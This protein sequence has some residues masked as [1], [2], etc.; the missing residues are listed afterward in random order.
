MERTVGSLPQLFL[1]AARPLSFW[2]KRDRQRCSSAELGLWPSPGPVI[3]YGLELD[4]VKDG[5]IGGALC[6]QYVCIGKQ[7]NA[8]DD[9]LSPH[10]FAA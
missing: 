1:R 2:R 8:A 3:R 7:C 9:H 10:R 5:Q 4:E 6:S